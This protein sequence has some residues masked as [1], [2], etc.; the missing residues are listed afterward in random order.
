MW[1]AVAGSSFIIL[2]LKIVPQTVVVPSSPFLSL[3]NIKFI[4]T[5]TETFLIGAQNTFKSL[6][7]CYLPASNIIVYSSVQIPKGIKRYPNTFLF[8]FFFFFLGNDWTRFLKLRDDKERQRQ[9]RQIEV[10]E[11]KFM[12]P[13]YVNMARRV[14]FMMMTTMITFLGF[15]LF[16]SSPHVS[17]A[18]FL[19]RLFAPCA[20]WKYLNIS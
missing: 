11:F 3:S 6:R 5:R 16:Q 1:F 19:P 18:L 4:T 7:L 20:I 15:M 9:W 10:L 2:I 17:P 12:F 14:F 8:F 13:F